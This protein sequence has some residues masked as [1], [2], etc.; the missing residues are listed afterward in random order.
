M[1]LNIELKKY[2]E[3]KSCLK[4]F[5]Y[6]DLLMR[7]NVSRDNSAARAMK[8]SSLHFLFHVRDYQV[9]LEI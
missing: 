8:T 4:L 2:E 3:K 1:P 9:Y 7:S 5:S 6:F